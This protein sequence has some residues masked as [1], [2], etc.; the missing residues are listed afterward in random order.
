M[1]SE[2]FIQVA[3]LDTG[4]SLNIVFFSED[5]EIFQTLAFL[6]FRL[7]SVCVRTHTR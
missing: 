3:N 4:C 6:C 2:G 5:F 7:V 1:I